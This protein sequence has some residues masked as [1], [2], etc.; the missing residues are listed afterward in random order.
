MPTS[1]RPIKE[2]D[3]SFL[4]RLYASTR[5]EE[6]AVLDWSEAQKEAFLQMQFNAQHKFYTEQFSQAE[7][8]IIE[9]DQEPIGRLYVDRR[10]DEIRLIDIA[11]LPAY[12]NRGIGSSYLIYFLV[13]KANPKTSG[14]KK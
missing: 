3:Q 11:L 8:Q 14:D 9:Q 1:L 5:Q 13:I 10:D 2:E 4:Y 7:F 12:R 6:L